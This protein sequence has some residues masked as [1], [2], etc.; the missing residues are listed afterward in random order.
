MRQSIDGFIFGHLYRLRKLS[1]SK[2]AKELELTFDPEFFDRIA[3]APKAGANF[4]ANRGRR[5]ARRSGLGICV[6]NREAWDHFPALPEYHGRQ[7]CLL[8]PVCGPSVPPG[9]TDAHAVKRALAS[10]HIGGNS[11]CHGLQTGISS[12][13]PHTSNWSNTYN[14]EQPYHGSGAYEDHYA[15]VRLGHN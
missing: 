2:R 13:S 11:N 9:Y 6:G 10:G 15:G 1:E 5:R 8:T 3:A 7:K 4:R 14:C 12:G